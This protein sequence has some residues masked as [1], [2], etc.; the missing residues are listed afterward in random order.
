MMELK[1]N[2]RITL[3]EIEHKDA[4]ELYALVDANR[5]HLRRFLGWV[6]ANQSVSDTEAFIAASRQLQQMK[7]GV[8][9]MIRYEGRIIG[10]IN[11]HHIDWMNHHTSIGYWLAEGMEGQGIMTAAV[12]RLITYAF[13]ELGLNRVE[14]RCAVENR[15]SRAIPERLGF[16]REGRIRQGEWLYNRYVDH[17]IY[18]LLKN[19]WRRD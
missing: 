10:V 11:L 16:I 8:T 1:V 6:D 18:S 12:K 13:D 9:Y 4:A 15:K 5:E 14:I 7:N 17:Y 3:R 19:E 2:E